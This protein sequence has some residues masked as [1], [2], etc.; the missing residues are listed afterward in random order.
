MLFSSV[1]SRVAGLLAVA[2]TALAGPA[3]LAPLD[4]RVGR[5]LNELTVR[6]PLDIAGVSHVEKRLTADFCLDHS[7]K[8]HVLFGG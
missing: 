1:Q 2:A 7:W 8:N 4:P 3:S 6:E 5:P